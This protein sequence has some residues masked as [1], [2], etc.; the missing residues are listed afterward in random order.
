MKGQDGSNQKSIRIDGIYPDGAAR[1]IRYLGPPCPAASRSSSRVLVTTDRG[2]GAPPAPVSRGAWSRDRCSRRVPAPATCSAPTS[3]PASTAPRC[4]PSS[5]RRDRAP[6]PTGSSWWAPATPS[7]GSPRCS[8]RDARAATTA[9]AATDGTA[10]AART[11][12]RPARGVTTAPGAV[13]ASAAKGGRGRPPPSGTRRAPRRRGRQVGRPPPLLGDPAPP[14]RPPVD[15]RPKPKRLRPNRTHRKAAL[16]E[17]PAEQQPVAEQVLKGGIPAVRAAVAKQNEQARAEGKPEVKADQLVDLAEK[18][19]PRLR[20]AEWRDRAEAAMADLEELD[21][22]DLRSVIVA[23]EGAARDDETRGP[24]DLAA[25]GPGP[26]GR[27]GA[28]R[29]AA[30]DRVD[31]RRGPGG[32]GPAAQLAPA[33]GRRSPPGRPR[34]PADRGDQRGARRRHRRPTAGPRCS[35]RSRSPR[36]T[37][38]SSRRRS[39]PSPTRRCSPRCG[40]PRRGCRR[41]P[42]GSASIR[43]PLPRRAGV[44]RPADDAGP[45]AVVPPGPAGPT[46]PRGQGR[47]RPP[48][49]RSRP[50]PR[51]RQAARRAG[52]GRPPPESRPSSEPAVEEPAVEEVAA[53]GAGAG[54]RAGAAAGPRARDPRGRAHPAAARSPSRA[55]HQLTPRRSSDLR[56]AR[57]G[58]ARRAGDGRTRS[59][60]TRPGPR[61]PRGQHEGAADGP[62]A[63]AVVVGVAHEGDLVAGQPERVEHRLEL[64]GAGEGVGEQRHGGRP[65]QPGQ[66]GPPRARVLVRADRPAVERGHQLGHPGERLGRGLVVVV[67]VVLDGQAQPL[68]L[69]RERRARRS[70]RSA[71]TPNATK[72]SRSAAS[73]SSKVPSRSN[74]GNRM[75]YGAL[76][77][78]EAAERTVTVDYELDGHIAVITIN[79]PEARNAVNRDVA[80]G[81]EAA[82]DR[83][84]DDDEA[85]VGIITG[86]RTDKGFIFSAGA[87]LKAMTTDAGGMMTKKGGFAGLVQR[88]RTKPI[89]AAVD[90]PALA[91]GTE[92]VLACDLVVASRTA[93]FGIPEVKRNLVAGAGGLFRLRPQAAPQ[94]RHGAGPHRPPRLPGRAGPP[95]RSGQRALRR[96]RRARCGQGPRRAHHARTRRSRC[97]RAAGSS[98]RRPT[99]PRRSAGSCRARA[100]PSCSAPRTSARASPPSPRSGHRVWKGR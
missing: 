80:E 13:R 53:A 62:S 29:V 19:L 86:A 2:P 43:R 31:P 52:R 72:A 65:A 25:G 35:T 71:G 28:E 88:E 70:R 18:L 26:P 66:L 79:R 21:L 93:V 78:T 8:R 17:L 45:V 64:L 81:I 12:G 75:P 6:S 4:S 32:A 5:R 10:A 90:G 37:C 100:W 3:R 84:E 97:G 34:R 89:I 15:T 67:E 82:V 20:A 92:I 63:R 33:E 24:R 98:S 54:R 87:D 9:I 16:A 42:P 99:S 46:R 85:W 57:A 38:G 60:A 1:C 61:V 94:R 58:R 36:S 59:D 95:L 91:G 47:R 50:H 76:P 7:S 41:S 73:V 39:R 22:R 48:T 51:S 56:C 83:L 30:G 55:G 14:P 23:A 74:T 96:G 40:P 68:A 69:V 49:R 44:A 27:P 77:W 11:A